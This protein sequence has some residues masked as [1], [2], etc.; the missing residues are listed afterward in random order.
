MET[1]SIILTERTLTPL[2]T[3]IATLQKIQSFRNGPRANPDG[4]LTS[5]QREGRVFG[6]RQELL[7]RI[8]NLGSGE[9]IILRTEDERM[10]LNIGLAI[11]VRNVDV[12]IEYSDGVAKIART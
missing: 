8:E 6:V 1:P 4:S 7:A 12:H 11:N 3:P 10:I 5:P 2:P 9:S